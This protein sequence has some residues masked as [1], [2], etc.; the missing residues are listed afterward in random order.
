MILKRWLTNSSLKER[1]PFRA[2]LFF[3]FALLTSAR[4]F[5]AA[6]D[7]PVYVAQVPN[8]NDYVLFA[9]GGWDGNW[10]VGY[11][12]C[13]VKK[14]P[15]IPPGQYARAYIGAKLG[16]MKT[17]PPVGRPP[18]FDPIPAEI[19]MALSST[20]AWKPSQ[21][22]KLTSTDDIPLET[23]PEFAL[24][25]T[26]E[27]EWY[28]TEVPVSALNL[29][30]DNF[31]ALW[32]PTPALVSVSS[33]PVL[34][35][36]WGGKDINTW[37]LNSIKGVPPTSPKAA[38]KNGLSYFQP[39][40]ALKLIPAGQPHPIH[41]QLVTWQNGSP[42]HLKPVLT[43]S[44]DG[45]SIERVWVEQNV[46][47]R[48][49][50]VVTGQWVQVGRSLWKAPYVFSLDQGKLAKGNVMLRVCAVNVWGE[51][52]ASDAFGIQVS[53]IGEKK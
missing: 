9:N 12:N 13:W 39:A 35:A 27:S 6:S 3:A 2:F 15:A 30:G 43:A 36:A 32:S 44:A 38:L 22:I 24:E 45:E 51:K 10:Y 8:P 46:H 17:L 47:N 50:D 28:W 16:R 20:P 19:W 31:L 40:L 29:S 11:N 53:P 7:Y 18:Q 4:L 33:S 49:G 21:R 25:N 26:G 48:R 34:A 1:K 5:A 14:L 37:L 52:A 41:V 23:S 42:D